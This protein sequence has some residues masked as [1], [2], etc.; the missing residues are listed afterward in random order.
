MFHPLIQALVL[1]A[2][3]P[4]RPVLPRGAR[5]STQ[6]LRAG[7]VAESTATLSN[8]S[9]VA[10]IAPAIP[11]VFRLTLFV[12]VGVMLT[13][14]TALPV[15]TVD[16]LLPQLRFNHPDFTCSPSRASS[17]LLQARIPAALFTATAPA[18]AMLGVLVEPILLLFRSPRISGG[19]NSYQQ[20]RRDTIYHWPVARSI[21]LI[22]ALCACAFATFIEMGKLASVRLG[23]KRS[24]S[25]RKRAA[26]RI[27]R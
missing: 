27:Q 24:R 7:Q 13:I 9:V 8:R 22:L 5:P 19:F 17:S 3:A 11:A 14:A 4:L 15:V 12:M 20:Y 25:C 1:F 16:P 21:P 26:D 18:V 6:S 23:R 10:S 2:A